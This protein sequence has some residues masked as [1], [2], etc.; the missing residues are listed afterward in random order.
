MAIER[1]TADP[2][3]ISVPQP[4]RPLLINL[5][6]PVSLQKAGLV[7]PGQLPLS[8][9]EKV[10]RELAAISDSSTWWLADWMLYGETAYT[11]R[12]REVIERTGLGYQTLRNYAWVA[13]RFPLERRHPELSFAHHAEV[14]SLEPPE[15]EYWLRWAEQRKWSRNQLRKELRAS[16]AE[17]REHAPEPAA[18][19]DGPRT[20]LVREAER[21]AGRLV[22]GRTLVARELRVRLT[23]DQLTRCEQLAVTR[24]LSVEDWAADVIRAALGEPTRSRVLAGTAAGAVA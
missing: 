14:A 4:R 18:V 10:G 2:A 3:T 8:V 1:S 15:Q 20:A 22:E 24:G 17:R 11:G 6:G 23:H 9:W 12:Y 7:I 19:P 16:L 21:V 5:A 13:R